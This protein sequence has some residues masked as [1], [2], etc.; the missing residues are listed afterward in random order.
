VEGWIKLHRKIANWQWASSP[1]HMTLFMQLLLRANHKETKWRMETIKSGQLL[2][3]RKQ[4]MEWTGLTE[5][6]IRKCLDDM[7]LTGEIVRKRSAKYS[8]ISI[9]NWETY[10]GDDRETSGKRPANVQQTST[11]KNDNNAN[12][13][14][15]NINIK[16]SPLSVLFDHMPEVQAWLNQGNH[17][18]HLLIKTKFPETVILAEVPGMYLWASRNNMRAETWMLKRLT[19]ID[20]ASYAPNRA[21]KSFSK[22]K[23]TGVTPTPQNP[24]GDPYLQEALDKGLVG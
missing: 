9:R 8:I 7:E 10:Q 19:N 2:T 13:E 17:D 20:T 3:G 23:G 18:T 1:N 14:K 24:T 16:P 4:L 12:N 15:N 11:S 22:K 5:R 21:E 6:Q